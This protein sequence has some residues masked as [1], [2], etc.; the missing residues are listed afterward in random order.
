M[1]PKLALLFKINELQ[2]VSRPLLVE[3]R[4]CQLKD[5]VGES[6]HCPKT[7]FIS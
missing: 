4:I 2:G 6:F 5:P 3:P 1:R 7:G